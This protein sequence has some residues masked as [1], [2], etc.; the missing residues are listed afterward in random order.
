MKPG[1]MIWII[2][3]SEN[4]LSSTTI[5][6]SGGSQRISITSSCTGFQS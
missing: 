2:D 6:G 5:G 4:G 3:D 1:D